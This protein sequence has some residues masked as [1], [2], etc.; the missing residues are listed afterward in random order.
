VPGA[1]VS[2]RASLRQRRRL[3]LQGKLRRPTSCEGARRRGAKGARLEWDPAC[4]HPED[5]ASAIRTAS[6]WQARQPV[7]RSSVDR[8]RR[9]EPWIGE[10]RS[11]VST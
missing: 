4:L 1:R 2:P 10:L 11:L 9:F 5:N 3:S 6:K 8:W 7:F